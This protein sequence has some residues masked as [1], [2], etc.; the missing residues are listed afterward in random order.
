MGAGKG[1]NLYV[2]HWAGLV[3]EDEKVGETITEGILK[4]ISTFLSRIKVL[5][6]I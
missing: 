1:C 6:L 3:K 4:V 5:F 2:S